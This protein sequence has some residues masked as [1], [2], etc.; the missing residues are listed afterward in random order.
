MQRV[1]LEAVLADP[2]ARTSMVKILRRRALWLKGRAR[3][4]TLALADL[5]EHA[6][7]PFPEVEETWRD[8]GQFNWQARVN[9]FTSPGSA[10]RMCAEN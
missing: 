10:A 6:E 8:M 4:D 5:Y 2:R 3:A 1:M 9:A 7:A